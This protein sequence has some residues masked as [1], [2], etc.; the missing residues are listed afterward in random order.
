MKD[1]DDASIFTF[2]KG[3]LEA[4]CSA[5]EQPEKLHELIC[6]GEGPDAVGRSSLHSDSPVHCEM[7]VV[8]VHHVIH[9]AAFGLEYF[10]QRVDTDSEIQSCSFS[11]GTVGVLLC[12]SG[13]VYDRKLSVKT[14]SCFHARIGAE[15]DECTT[16]PE[17]IRLYS[18]VASQIALKR[19]EQ[20]AKAA[21][22][23]STDGLYSDLMGINPNAFSSHF[24]EILDRV[25]RMRDDLIAAAMPIEMANK[26]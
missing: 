16:L 2:R 24:V 18:E 5:L 4:L 10:L 8:F 26:S 25:L 17:L 6:F 22:D 9:L 11:D 20:E 21:G 3:L 19:H 13:L 12:Q 7:G 23:L 15:T 1:F 14:F